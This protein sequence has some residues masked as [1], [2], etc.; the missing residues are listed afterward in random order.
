MDN[1]T[2]TL[3]GVLLARAGLNRWCSGAGFLLALAANAPDVDVVAGLLGGQDTYLEWHRGPTHGLAGMPVVALLPLLA[4]WPFRRGKGQWLRAYLVSLAAVGSHLALDWTN[5]YGIRLLAPFS[6]EWF[7]ADITGVVD[8][9]IW[10]LLAGAALWGILARLVSTEIGARATPGRGVA[11]AALT[12]LCAYDFGRFLLHER[13]VAVLDSHL[14]AGEV[15]TR[16]A[17]FPGFALPMRWTGVVETGGFYMVHRLDLGAAFDPGAGKIYYKAAPGEALEAARR[18]E[19]FRKFLRF[20]QFPIWRQT[21][22]AE[23]EGGV[24]VEVSDLRF[25]LPGDGRFAAVAELD[26]NQRV[27]RAWFQ[28]GPGWEKGAREP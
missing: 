27:L 20:A 22:L 4:M 5:M 24:R 26:Q 18:T 17:A 10:A 7:R 8:V 25:G 1:L 16:V 15:P 13:A 11:I 9:W 23:P 14:Y 3:T 12:L 21:P 6:G 2:H 28:F 19:A